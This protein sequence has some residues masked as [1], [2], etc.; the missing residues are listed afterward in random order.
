MLL[1]FELYFYLAT[2]ENF[3]NGNLRYYISERE[4]VEGPNLVKLV[5]RYFKF[6]SKKIALKTFD[7]IALL[8][9]L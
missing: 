9:G 2:L 8:K 4:V 1:L 5:F 7:L 3:L 6:F